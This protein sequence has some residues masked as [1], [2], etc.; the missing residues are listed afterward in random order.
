MTSH[1]T[2]QPALMPIL[3][4]S[5]RERA[6]GRR[7]FELLRAIEAED[8]RVMEALLTRARERAT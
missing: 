7:R 1:F 6:V 8:K 5:V 3:D 4:A 2:A